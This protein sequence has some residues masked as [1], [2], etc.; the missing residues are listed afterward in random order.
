MRCLGQEPK[1][2]RVV[3]EAGQ[4]EEKSRDD[5]GGTRQQGAE[6]HLRVQLRFEL[7]DLGFIER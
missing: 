5:P 7:L 6:T 1:A 4:T 2:G 3:V